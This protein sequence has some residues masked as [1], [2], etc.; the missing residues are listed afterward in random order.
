MPLVYLF[1]SVLDLAQDKCSWTCFDTGQAWLV[2][3]G[4][5]PDEYVNC[6]LIRL[7]GEALGV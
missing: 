5:H 3:D 1:A 4:Y 2:I 7:M 6:M